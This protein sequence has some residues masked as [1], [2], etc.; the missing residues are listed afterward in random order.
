MDSLT[1]LALKKAESG[2]GGGGGSDSSYEKKH[3]ETLTANTSSTTA[4]KIKTL[5]LQDDLF[6]QKKTILVAIRDLAGK[7][8]G[9]IYGSIYIKPY[10]AS[11]YNCVYYVN[12]SGSMQANN[13]NRGVYISSVSASGTLTQID[14][15]T[16]YDSTY[17]TID[18]NFVIDV[19][20]ANFTDGFAP[21][22]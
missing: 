21:F 14:V 6:E 4:T 17:G 15:S 20:L 11:S 5:L 9:Y 22:E 3:T 18:G 19:Y 12:S 8:N 13:I 10:G 1:I 16:R 7:R 2:G